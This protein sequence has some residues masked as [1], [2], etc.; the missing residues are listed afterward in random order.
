MGKK[1][2]LKEL[3]E[4]TLE[5]IIEKMKGQETTDEDGNVET[6]PPSD[7]IIGQAISYLTKNNISSDKEKKVDDVAVEA[8]REAK[9]KREA[10]AHKAKR[11]ADN[12][13]V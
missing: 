10:N 11:K 2:L 9:A 8:R 1:E 5:T 4:L 7:F 13:E 6:E 12:D 3:D